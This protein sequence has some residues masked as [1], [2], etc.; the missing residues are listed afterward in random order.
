MQTEAED[1]QRMKL[2]EDQMIIDALNGMLFFEEWTAQNKAIV[3]KIKSDYG[4]NEMGSS[5]YLQ[6]LDDQLRQ[7][8]EKLSESY[9]WLIA[10]FAG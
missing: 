4:L 7:S 1:Q 6:K 8:F 3:D 5:T 10:K 9:E 2:E